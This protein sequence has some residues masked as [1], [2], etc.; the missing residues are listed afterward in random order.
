MI[1]ILIFGFIGMNSLQSSFFPEVESRDISIRAIYPGAS[2]EEVERGIILKI[3]DN[4][5]GLS[6]IKK[7]ESTAQENTGSVNVEIL[8]G[9]DIDVVLADV[10]NAVDQ[11]SSFP[12]GM[13]PVVVYKL[14]SLNFA[15]GVAIKGDLDLKTLK[16]YAREVED[17]LRGV[18]GISKVDLSG[19]PDEE[20]EIAFRE[21]DLQ[22]YDLTFAEATLAVRNANIEVTGGTVKGA[23]EELIVRSNQKGYFAKDLVHI[24]LKTTESG[25]IVRLE[26][27]ADVNDKWADEPN[28]AYINGDPAVIINIQNTVEEDIL[29]ITEYVTDYVEK[30]NASNDGVEAI[31]TRD[32]SISLRQRIDL[33][34]NNGVLGFFL[35][36]ILLAMFLNYRM[37][38]WVALAIPVS[39]AGMFMIVPFT[40]LTINV[41]SLFA[42]I[43]VIG[44]LVDDGIVI[45][46]NI[47]RHFEMGKT[48][49]Q[50]AID[51]TMEVL[52]AVFSA[53]LTTV[54]AFSTFI[55][56]DGQLGDFFTEM[57][58]VVI[59]T[60]IF[61]LVEG[62]FILPEHIGHSKALNRDED[63]K[64][65]L[66]DR[67]FGSMSRTF[68]RFMVF[69]RDKL[70]APVLK[71]SMNN[72]FF[73][74]AVAFGL[75]FVSFA[76][77]GGGFV[78]GTFFPNID[79][80]DIAVNLQLESGTREQYVED[81]LAH[82]E[83][84]TWSVNEQLKST[85]ADGKDVVEK[86]Q[87]TVG[88]TTY[89]GSLSIS[90]LN[91]EERDMES[92]DIGNLIREEAGPII[93]AESVT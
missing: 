37:A 64:P 6:G 28:R 60:L 87:R 62:A 4:L 35:V 39:F 84:A 19:F 42:M 33:L 51:G 77:V 86:V 63:T 38:F 43:L 91:G 53:I 2:P 23:Q 69:M 29:F 73:A 10:K 13:E 31:I 8:K 56:L 76:L 49:K 59:F 55:F 83:A 5:K 74:L 92:L 71:F 90:L 25:I 79:G 61:S 16:H 34:V 72:K 52:P 12:V 21:S 65:N 45:S 89:Q 82:I 78:K 24:P 7:V 22:N 93:G 40:G 20:I 11:V 57:S 48:K 46:E 27:V 14:E 18:P 36:L 67:I 58:W 54:I 1:I 66:P 68:D 32:G 15:I 17:D 47:F 41:V 44:I 50:A 70:Y 80:D 88:P 85:R 3:E 30:F 26:D 75:M 81:W 9:Y